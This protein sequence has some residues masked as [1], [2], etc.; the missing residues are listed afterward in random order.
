[1][2]DYTTGLCGF[3]MAIKRG[4]FS[5]VGFLI[6]LVLF[7]YSLMVSTGHDACQTSYK[8]PPLVGQSILI[9]ISLVSELAITTLTV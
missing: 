5:G 2:V 7:L 8:V 3:V 6:L 9:L 1:M 4:S